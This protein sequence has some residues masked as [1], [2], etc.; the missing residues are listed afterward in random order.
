MKELLGRLRHLHKLVE[1][2]GCELVPRYRMNRTALCTPTD[3][4]KRRVH[5]LDLGR[6]FPVAEMSDRF[7]EVFSLVL[8]ARED[9]CD[10]GLREAALPQALVD[11]PV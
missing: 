3:E 2:R 10:R 5:S 7:V 9:L 8:V 4:A 1:T 11:R 6:R